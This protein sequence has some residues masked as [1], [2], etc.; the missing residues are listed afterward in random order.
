MKFTPNFTKREWTRGLIAMCISMLIM[1]G[2]LAFIPGITDAQLNFASFLSDGIIVMLFL[3]RFLGRNITAALDHPLRTLYLAALGYLANMAFSQMTAIVSYLLLPDYV[4][5]NDQSIQSQLTSETTLVL[6][7]TV[8][9]APIVEECFFRGLL[10]RGLYDRSPA[11][12]WTASVVLFSVVHIA[13]FIG[14]YSPLALLVSFI[15]YLPAGIVLCV[16]YQRSGNIIAPILTHVF[17]NLMAV[18]ATL[19]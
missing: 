9:L 4:N 1:P 15:T 3:R 6:L 2:L 8:V 10:F 19:R 17:I 7:T 16:T 14:W 12:A 13:A 5:L 11:A 18:S